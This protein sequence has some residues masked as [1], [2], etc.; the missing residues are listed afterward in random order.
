M[1]ALL[2]QPLFWVLIT[3]FL[4]Q[5]LVNLLLFRRVAFYKSSL[6][7]VGSPEPISVII[8]ARNEA[9]NI[10]KYLQTVLEQ[11]Y[12]EFEVIVINDQ[13]WDKTG[14]RLEEIAASYP[15]LKI[16]TIDEHVNEFAGKKLA[17]TLGAKAAI[18]DILVFTDADCEPASK[19]WLQYMAA[20]YRD[21]NIE[22]VIGYSP[23][24]KTGGFLNKFIRFE[25][26][27]TALYYFSFALGGNPYMGVG[28]NLSYRKS[29]FFRK[30]GFAPYLK[31]SAGDDDLFVNLHSNAKNTKAVLNPSS[32]VNS[33]PKTTFQDWYRQKKRHLSV[34]KYYKSGHR[35]SLAFL[36]FAHFIFYAAFV[37]GLIFI[38]PFW[39]AF[40]FLGLGLL[41]QYGMN[42]S[43]MK[44]LEVIDILPFYPFML[45]IHNAVYYPLMGFF[46]LFRR[47]KKR[48]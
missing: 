24:Q 18:Y 15:N 35:R 25:T 36:W 7:P 30:K 10:K 34:G 33:S 12:P 32:F 26:Y 39:I 38:Q 3:V 31:V 42:Y 9:E 44:K 45:F 43:A 23:Y 8:A 21:Q 29:L 37:L 4:I 20:P 13:S 28:R 2:Y 11:D 17:L 19:L 40:V 5:L 1:D 48:W 14:Y 6:E 46:S 22:I 27:L 41:L 47:K 16:V